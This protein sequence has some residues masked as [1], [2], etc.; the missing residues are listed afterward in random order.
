MDPIIAR[1]TTNG[2]LKGYI[3][4]KDGREVCRDPMVWNQ[5]RG[6]ESYIVCEK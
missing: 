1:V 2:M 5:F 3:V 6:P 4:Q